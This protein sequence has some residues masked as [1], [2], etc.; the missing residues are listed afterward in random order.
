MIHHRGLTVVAAIV[1]VFIS[2]A[3]IWLAHAWLETRSVLNATELRLAEQLAKRVPSEKFEAIKQTVSEAREPR[4]GLLFAT[5]KEAVSRFEAIFRSVAQ[6]HGAE[7]LSFASMTNTLN[8]GFPV[9]ST[10]VHFLV[11]DQRMSSFVKSLEDGPPAVFLDHFKV[12]YQSDSMDDNEPPMLEAHATLTV[13]RDN[14]K[15]LMP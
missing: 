9:V 8:G 15:G 14:P 7:I 6:E 2:T 13:Y 11:S 4:T 10:K 12:S 5:D 1:L 3:C